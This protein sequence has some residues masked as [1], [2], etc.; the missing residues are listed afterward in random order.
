MA[1]CLFP[2]LTNEDDNPITG[3][4]GG[5][6]SRTESARACLKV[7]NKYIN[8][9][10]LLPPPATNV[11]ETICQGERASR[12]LSPAPLSLCHRCLKFEGDLVSGLTECRV[13]EILA[14]HLA[15]RGKGTHN[16]WSGTCLTPF[17]VHL[18]ERQ[19]LPSS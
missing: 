5:L 15:M 8:K 3:P 12:L 6:G 13:L 10:R 18:R 2:C 14:A 11:A 9:P 4:A 7:L 1:L 17:W 19:V 16:C